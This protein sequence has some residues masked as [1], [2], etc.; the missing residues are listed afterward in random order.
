M[1]VIVDTRNDKYFIV[2]LPDG[3]IKM[4]K[5]VNTEKSVTEYLKQAGA[6][7]IVWVRK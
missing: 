5:K 2:T 6:T 4:G 7:E 3:K 1:K